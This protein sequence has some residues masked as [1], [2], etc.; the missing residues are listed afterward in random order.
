MAITGD[1]MGWDG[2][3]A[4]AEREKDEKERSWRGRGAFVGAGEWN[5]VF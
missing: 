4:E 2:T 3:R 5:R 1:G